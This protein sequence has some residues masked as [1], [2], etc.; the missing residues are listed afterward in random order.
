MA[1]TFGQIRKRS[2]GR[3]QAWYQHH[4]GLV[5]RAPKTF[6]T[7]KEAEAWLSAEQTRILQGNWVD[8]R[9][10]RVLLSE[11]LAHWLDTTVDGRVGSDNTRHSYAAS[12]KRITDKIGHYY[13][14]D[15]TSEVIDSFLKALADEGLSRSYVNRIRTHLVQALDF[16]M[17]R[18]RVSRNVATVATMPRCKPPDPGRSYSTEE[19]A[20]FL[21][22]AQG[23]R[24]EALYILGFH[25]GPRPGEY[26]GFQWSDFDLSDDAM[27]RVQRSVK[28]ILSPLARAERGPDQKSQ[29]IELGP[30]KKSA[31][32][33]GRTVQLP[34]FLISTLRAHKKRQLEERMASSRWEDNDLVFCSRTGTPL[35]ASNLRKDFQ[36]IARK[37]GIE[38]ATS[39]YDM[40]HTVATTLLEA[41]LT[42]DEVAD[43][44]GNTALT[45]YRYYKHSTGK[46]STTGHRMAELLGS[47]GQ[48][49]E[50]NSLS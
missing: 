49:A 19:V 15:L 40:R 3:W 34:L 27:V 31:G 48:L 20:R 50:G 11:W 24:L 28:R 45:V 44:L 47:F 6:I 4:N 12:C 10:G 46:V 33:G 30:I 25:L 26:G 17:N 41:G 2:S 37:A 36:R 29:T 42:A 13:L 14:N 43:S 5:V 23:E 1:R 35:D 22:A 39:P 16:A 38:G 18:N 7:R 21:T 9:A 8:P 32:A